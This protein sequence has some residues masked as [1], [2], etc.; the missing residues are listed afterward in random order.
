MII[1]YIHNKTPKAVSYIMKH[2][3]EFMFYHYYLWAK[4]E[5]KRRYEWLR[6]KRSEGA[7]GVPA[8]HRE[9]HNLLLDHSNYVLCIEENRVLPGFEG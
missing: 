5:P 8:E 6:A 2:W 4:I 9:A 3:D 7:G 1:S